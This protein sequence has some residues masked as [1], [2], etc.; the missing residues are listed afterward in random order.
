MMSGQSARRYNET[1]H[2]SAQVFRFS[3]S[4]TSRLFIDAST[5][6]L[7]EFLERC[8]S[9]FDPFAI[10]IETVHRWGTAFITALGIS[11]KSSKKISLFICFIWMS[12]SS[13]QFTVTKCE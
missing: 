11:V 8:L 6:Q 10:L 4:S 13:S 7:K 5:K 9:D 1:I 2:E 12:L 3:L